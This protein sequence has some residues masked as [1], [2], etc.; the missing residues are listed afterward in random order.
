V[1]DQIVRMETVMLDGSVGRTASAAPPARFGESMLGSSNRVG[2]R[3]KVSWDLVRCGCVTLVMVYHATFTSTLLHPELGTRPFAFPYQVAASLLLVLSAY[4]ACM[5]IQRGSLLR[6]WVSRMAR[7]LP[8]FVAAV[9]VIYLTLRMFPAPGWFE[10]TP[11]DLAAN[12]FMLTNWQPQSPLIDGSHW[13][14]P[15]QL[16]GFTVAALLFRSRWGHGRRIVIVLWSA[17]LLGMAQWPIRVSN[18][19]ALYPVLADGFGIHRWHL[20]VAG[21]A[22]W[23]WS[24]GRIR[25]SHFAGLIATCM[26]AQALHTST[27][28]PDGPVVN[29]DFVV[30]VGIGLCVI[31]LAARGPDWDT[32]V[33]S[34]ATRAVQ[35]YAGVSYGVFLMHQSLGYLVMRWLNDLG[36]DPLAQTVGMVC[37]GITLGWVLTRTVEGPAYRL[38]MHGFDRWAD[39][40][41][42]SSAENP[43][44]LPR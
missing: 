38:V 12:L 29:W 17:L 41:E 42:G 7:L 3:R 9:L 40:T 6:Y 26:A 10:P 8:A 27:P 36:L 25:T 11:A 32:V 4:F 19:S 43:Q 39:R 37:A 21:A 33:P 15:L 2:S 35:W 5:T 22:I 44:A 30:P 23:L 18:V 34:W 16:M 28:T 24:T 1:H 13:T 20:F 31:A 14:I